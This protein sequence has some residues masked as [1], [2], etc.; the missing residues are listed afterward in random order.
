MPVDAQ[1]LARQAKTLGCSVNPDDAGRLLTY[2][3][4]MLEANQQ[5][6]LTGIRDRDQAVV[7]H[8]LDSLA[9]GL[10]PI[11]PGRCLDLGSGNG[12]PGVALSILWPR[13]RVVLMDRTGKKVRAV[14]RCLELA[15]LER[16]TA[17]HMDAAMVPG[18]QP[19]LVFDLVAVRAV[20]P[21]FTLAPIAAPQ[22]SRFPAVHG[23][24][25]HIGNPEAIGITDITKPDFGEPV[26]FEEGEVPVFWACGVTPQAVA[27]SAKP[28]LM[29]THAPGHMF[30]TDRKDEDLAVL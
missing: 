6:N 23:A 7:L 29:I 24:P 28:P 20:S 8:I 18:L 2:L 22:T 14:Q 13:A 10:L 16:C 11:S 9:A 3:D 19:D 12:F 21:P 27:M 15:G 4:A 26:A 17:L 30:I 25:V 1:A 5:L